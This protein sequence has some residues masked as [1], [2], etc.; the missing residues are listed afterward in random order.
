MEKRHSLRPLNA[1]VLLG[2]LGFGT[3]AAAGESAPA[4]GDK[5]TVTQDR[6]AEIAMA[7]VPGGRIVEG[8][9]EKEHG[10]LV[11]SF[12]IARPGSKDLAEIQVD[13]HSGAIVS[14][15]TE[16]PAQEADENDHEDMDEDEGTKK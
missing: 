2:S 15:S 3:A 1:L 16:T 6:A 9:L 7:R 8:E 10:K 5:A 4:P 13:A 14:E 11:W 12:D